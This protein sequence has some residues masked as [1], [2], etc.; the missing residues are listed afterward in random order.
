MI[1]LVLA[2]ALNRRGRR[3]PLALRRRAGLVEQCQGAGEVEMVADLALHGHGL[4]RV[5]DRPAG[6]R[7]G[8]RDADQGGGLARV[9][10]RVGGVEPVR[11]S[12][13]R[14]G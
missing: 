11:R 4:T 2:S 8:G 5:L 13:E 12:R 14:Q 10:V 6:M 7:S 9:V 3:L 1:M